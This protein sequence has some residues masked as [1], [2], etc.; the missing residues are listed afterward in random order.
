MFDQKQFHDAIETDVEEQGVCIMSENTKLTADVREKLGTS[1]TRKL[2]TTG[3]VPGSLYGLGKET[4]ALSTTEEALRPLIFGGTKVVDVEVG[5]ETATAIFREVQWDTFSQYVQHFDLQRLDPTKRVAVEI[6][7]EMKGTPEGVIAGGVLDQ[8]HRTVNI[9]CLV[10][11]IPDHIY[12][13]VAE[14][15]IGDALHISDLELP[16]GAVVLDDPTTLVVRVNAPMS[17]EEIEEGIAGGGPVEPEL[18]GREPE[19]EGGED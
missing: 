11:Q 13:R 15:Q 10:H 2:R 12:V 14:M 5:G 7:L 9:E 16:A 4:V 3:R 6:G 1:A 18:V 19:E 17:E 8:A